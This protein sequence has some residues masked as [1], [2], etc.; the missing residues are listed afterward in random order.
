MSTLSKCRI[1]QVADLACL[2]F[3]EEDRDFY[4]TH[5]DRTL[6]YFESLQ[7]VDVQGV[8]PM[9]T[10]HDIFVPLRE[11]K[12]QVESDREALL[13]GAPEVKDQQFKVPPVV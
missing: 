4:Q 8:V 10:P 1:E 9:I 6:D 11:D 7:N 13:K 5:I 3:D 2:S 12:I